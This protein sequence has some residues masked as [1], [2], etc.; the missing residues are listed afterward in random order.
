MGLMES[1]MAKMMGR[2]SVEEKQ[3]MM[4]KMMANMFDDM[5]AEEKAQ[6]MQGMMPAM[7]GKMM[8]G[9]SPMGESEGFNPKEMCKEMM[10]SM[11]QG[12]QSLALISPEIR[13]IF[14]DWLSHIEAELLAGME[15]EALLDIE[16]AMT[17]LNLSR[18]SVVYLIARLANADRVIL[19]VKKRSE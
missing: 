13:Q 5:S 9:A 11:Q 8:G 7:M 4:E 10:A 12:S 19:S 14:E 15:A 1:M 16:G 6:M 17:K 3:A 2:M 18:E